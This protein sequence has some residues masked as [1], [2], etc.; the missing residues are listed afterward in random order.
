[1]I[2]NAESLSQ[3]TEGQVRLVGSRIPSQGGVQVCIGLKWGTVCRDHW[4]NKDAAVVCYQLGYGR[5]GEY[6]NNCCLKNIIVIEA[7][8]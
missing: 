1:M 2:I 5:D 3:C 8:S 6:I 4:D 7:W